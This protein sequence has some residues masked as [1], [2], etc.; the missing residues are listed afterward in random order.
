MVFMIGLWL[1]CQGPGF[2]PDAES[3]ALVHHTAAGPVDLV[4]DAAAKKAI[5][6]CLQRSKEVDASVRPKLALADGSYDITFVDGTTARVLTIAT[7]RFL[8]DGVR[9]WENDCALALVRAAPPVEKPPAPGEALPAEAPPAE[10]PPLP[11]E[12]PKG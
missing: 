5:A 9:I 3:I 7:D 12:V 8:E 4:T 1:A 11:V 2:R 6:E 10:P